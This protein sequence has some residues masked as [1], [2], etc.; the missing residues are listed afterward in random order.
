MRMFK[1]KLLSEIES[2]TVRYINCSF[3]KVVLWE[4]MSKLWKKYLLICHNCNFISNFSVNLVEIKSRFWNIPSHLKSSNHLFIFYFLR[5]TKP[6]YAQSRYMVPS[7]GQPPPSMSRPSTVWRWRS[8]VGLSA[9]RDW[10]VS[11]MKMSEGAWA[12]RP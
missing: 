9:S 2:H 10:T 3:N 12:W 1:I 8:S 4:I 11:G 5:F 6:S 7:V